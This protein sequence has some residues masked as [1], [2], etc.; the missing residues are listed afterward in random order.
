MSTTELPRYKN[1]LIYSKKQC[2]QL[3]LGNPLKQLNIRN[4][5]QKFTLEVIIF[6]IKKAVKLVISKVSKECNIVLRKTTIRKK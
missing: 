3:K 2:V 1:I 4:V 6:L 5:A